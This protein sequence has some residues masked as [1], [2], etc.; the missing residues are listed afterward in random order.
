MQPVGLPAIAWMPPYV[1][2]V[3]AATTPHAP[4]ARWSIHQFSVSGSPVASSFP[5]EVQYPSPLISS[6]GIEPSMTRTYGA[7]SSP[8]AAARKGFMNS[9]PPRVGDSTLL[10]RCTLGRPGM[11]PSITSSSAGNLAAVTDTE[12]PS[13]LIPSEIQRMCT[14][15]TPVAAPRSAV[16]GSTSTSLLQ[17]QVRPRPRSRPI[18]RAAPRRGRRPRPGSRTLGTRTGSRL[19]RARRRSAGSRP[20]RTLPR[21]RGPRPRPASHARRAR[22]Q[23]QAPRAPPVEA[24]LPAPQPPSPSGPPHAALRCARWRRRSRARASAD[25][26][27][28]IADEHV[29]DPPAAERCLDEHHPRRLRLHLADLGRLCATRSRAER[30][31]PLVGGLGGDEGDERALVRDVHR[32]DAEDLAGARDRRRNRHRRLADDDG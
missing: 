23:R 9:S 14:S 8:R 30:R 12:S 15:S 1:A 2:Q 13:Q 4:G 18:P 7:S 24:L 29:H 10:C 19:P 26:R 31:E 20:P 16:V 28:G 32:V 21:A 5:N 6:F 22:T 3:P 27:Q 11:R 25:P 17:S